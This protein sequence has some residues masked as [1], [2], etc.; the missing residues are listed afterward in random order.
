VL[1]TPV[2]PVMALDSGFA[3]AV[4]RLTDTATWIQM[5][6]IS[7]AVVIMVVTRKGLS[8]RRRTIE[9]L[10][11]AITMLVMLAGN[12]LLNEHVVKPMFGIPRPNI[13]TLAEEGALGDA[14]PTADAFYASGDKEARRVL[15][16]DV[17]P[18]VRT[19]ALSS[20]VGAHWI[21]ETGYSFP[22]GHTTAAMTLTTMLT[23]IGLGW[24]SGWRRFLC[25]VVAP[26]W[27]V[28][29]AYSRVLLG[30]H[31]ALDVIVATVVGFGWGMLAVGVIGRVAPPL[32][33]T[34]R[35]STL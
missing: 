31:T 13:V 16:G 6:L 1:F 10:A 2:L 33:P 22:S 18:A 17:L 3:D 4:V 28:A 21:H 34:R 30:V 27:A 9:A 29:V 24:L 32:I 7:A 25:L 15:L 20:L 23:A 14:I 8:R 19:P 11:I 5:T 35:D 26:I 12:A